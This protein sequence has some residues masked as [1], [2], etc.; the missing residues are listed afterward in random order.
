MN[1]IPSDYLWLAVG[2]IGPI[3]FSMRF[4]VQWIASEKKKSSVVPVSFWYYSIAG[5]L[6]LL[7]YALHQRDPVFIAGQGL[8]VLIYLRN[9]YF[10]HRKKPAV[11]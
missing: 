7:V 2:L 5:G 4:V 10:I 9:L 6:V 8:G 1:F 3:L 11:P